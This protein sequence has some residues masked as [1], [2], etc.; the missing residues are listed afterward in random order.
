MYYIFASP[1]ETDS[2]W[3]LPFGG[4]SQMPPGTNRTHIDKIPWYTSGFE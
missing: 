1:G 4:T 3:F 2:I